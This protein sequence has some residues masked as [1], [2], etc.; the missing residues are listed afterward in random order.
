MIVFGAAR[1]GRTTLGISLTWPPQRQ[2]SPFTSG[3][4][5]V[6][7]YSFPPL[8]LLLPWYPRCLTILAERVYA[9]LG[10][11][12]RPSIPVSP[13]LFR[14]SIPAII[15]ASQTLSQR[16]VCESDGRHSVCFTHL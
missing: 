15:L 5:G 10:R 7:L 13:S 6:V 11:L 14:S 1:P 4:R 16:A 2:V 8:V 9:Y 12:W 3:G